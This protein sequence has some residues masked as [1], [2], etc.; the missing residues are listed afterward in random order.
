MGRLLKTDLA[1]PGRM[2]PLRAQLKEIL[3]GLKLRYSEV[4]T[5]TLIVTGTKD[6]DMSDLAAEAQEAAAQLSAA[7]ATVAMIE[8]SGHYPQLDRPQE[9]SAAIL[10]FLAGA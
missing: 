3:D 9:T 2:G 8:E 6:P 1:R 7:P 4:R 5:P 10:K